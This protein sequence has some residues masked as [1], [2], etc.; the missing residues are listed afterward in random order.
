MLSEQDILERVVDPKRGGFSPELAEQ[1]LSLDFPPA[2]HAKVAELSA[3]AQKG[4]L[5]ESE[6]VQLQTYLN[7]NDFLIFMKARA[8]I[9]LRKHNPAA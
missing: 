1:I 9:S 3:K 7:V 2:N 8:R 5:T 4:T 6:N